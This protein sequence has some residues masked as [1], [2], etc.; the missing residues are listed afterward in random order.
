MSSS[1]ITAITARQVVVP[2]DSPVWL[3]GAAVRERVYCVVEI[4]T[5]DGRQGH[6]LAFTRGADLVT[7]IVQQIAPLLL[8]EDSDDVERLWERIY[9]AVRLNGRQ[10]ILMRALSLIDL[11]LWDV[12]AKRS[13]LPL[14]RLLGGYRDSIPVMMAGGYYHADKDVPALC[15]EFLGY[16][17]EGYQHLKLI[18]GG[19]TMEEDLSRFIAVRN[20]LP[21]DI[22]LGVDANGAWTDPKAVL[23]WVQ[24]CQSQTRG[25]AFIE[26]PL[27]PEN[28]TGLAW[29]RDASPVPTAVGEFFSGRWTF[30]EYLSDKCMDIVRADA[31]L[32]GGISE[33][34]KI[35]AL[36]NAANLPLMPH[37]F[38]SIH[39]HL[40][41]ALPGC[42][43]IEVVS[44]EGRNS[45]FHLIA[46]QSYRLEKGLAHP[47]GRP[48]LGLELD[49]E[50]I[51]GHTTHELTTP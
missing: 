1:S 24:Q 46:G 17:A 22:D 6:A 8:Q 37:Y 43:R 32:C 42:S 38:A 19:A 15:A 27:P 25:V 40:A 33:W 23:R 2:L 51:T 41:L 4:S 26:E 30:Q 35:A 50:F 36:A 45:S 10:G 47:T 7:P 11:A 12:K 13:G 16:A 18:V 48:G 14:H 34:R 49:Y 31:T 44:R 9:D 28:R 39:F 5:K 3:G 29:L 20:S 21:E